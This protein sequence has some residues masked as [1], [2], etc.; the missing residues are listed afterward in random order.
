MITQTE[1]S[2]I[3]NSLGSKHIKKIQEHLKKNNIVTSQGRPYSK[4]TISYILSGERENEAI[5]NAI[6]AFAHQKIIEREKQQELRELLIAKQ[7][8]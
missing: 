4:A 2:A 3:I 6:F 7:K 8:E 1:R 5:E